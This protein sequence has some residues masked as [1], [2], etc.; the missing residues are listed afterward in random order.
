MANLF[1]DGK[2]WTEFELIL[3]RRGEGLRTTYSLTGVPRP[4][5]PELVAFAAETERF[6]DLKKLF[7]NENPFVGNVPHLENKETKN[8][9]GLP[10]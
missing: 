1:V 10:F 4:I 2:H 9:D 7:S 8:P 3:N 5:E 6:I